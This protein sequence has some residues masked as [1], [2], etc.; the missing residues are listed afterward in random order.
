LRHNGTSWVANSNLYNNGTNV[1]I[2]TTA[3]SAPLTIQQNSDTAGFRLIG[4]SDP[5][6]V[7]SFFIGSGGTNNPRFNSTKSMVFEANGGIYFRGTSAVFINDNNSANVNLVSGGGRVGI[8]TSAPVAQLDIAGSASVTNQIRLSGAYNTVGQGSELFLRENT[9]NDYGF[10]VGYESSVNKLYITSVNSSTINERLSILRNSG[11]VGIGTTTP[12]YK[13]DVSG[14][15]RF[16]QPVIVGTPNDAN[17]A[18]TKSYVDSAAGGGIPSAINGYTLR[19][20]GTSWVANSNLY[21]NGTNVGIG[22]TNPGKKLEVVGDVLVANT[23][24][25]GFRYSAGDSNF[26]NYIS[27]PASSPLTLSGGLWTSSDVQEA[28]R[29]ETKT[30]GSAKMSILNNGNVG[31]GTTNP[32]YKLDIN[33]PVRSN[34]ILNTNDVFEKVFSGVSFPNGVANQAVDIRLG[35]LSFWGYIEVEVNSTY[36]NQNSTGKLTKIF[37]VGTNPDNNIYTNESRISDAMGT[38]PNNMAIGDLVWDSTNSTY[39]IP[40]SHIVS[41]GNTFTVKVKMFSASSRAKAVFDSITLSE[42]YALTALPRQYVYYNSNVG[43]G[44]ATPAYKLDVAGTGRFTQPVIVGTPNA[45]DHAATKS[46]VDSAA[47]GGVGAGTSGQTLRH[48]G[49]SWVANSVLYNNGSSVG[50]GT[51]APGTYKLNVAGSVYIGGALQL[52]AGSNL[53]TSGT[54]SANK[55]N[56]GTIDPLY[57]LQGTN[58]ASF[59]ASVVGGV[60]EETT[61]RVMIDQ[62]VADEYQKTIDFKRQTVGSDL[63]VW[64][65]VID[66]DKDNVEVLLTPYGKPANVYYSISEEKLTF[67]SDMPVEVSYRLI[68]KRFDWKDWPTKAKDQNEKPNFILK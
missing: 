2:G 42:L 56:V 4:H 17:H 66:F 67:H 21:N 27:A 44:T 7:F 46:Y 20:S 55:I 53:V 18:A 30:V 22:T 52:S 29:F 9:A 11:N 31:I 40:L 54:I 51:T 25:I 13:L 37:A 36:A 6:T 10:K 47:G 23:G 57:N 68:A 8:G 3:P 49:T 62:A 33:G 59:A 5:T 28:I 15:G 58:Y 45:P 60:K 26:Y 38:I 19:A 34:G 12:A 16:T 65:N 24:K 41:S 1:G 50:I 35:N 61:G 39:K 32:G 43:I 64:Y 63:W 48:N 14:T